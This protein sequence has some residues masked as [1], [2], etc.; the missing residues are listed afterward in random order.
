MRV[1][2]LNIEI[3]FRGTS[4][5]VQTHSEKTPIVRLSASQ[6]QKPHSYALPQLVQNLAKVW[7]V[8]LLQLKTKLVHHI[9]HWVGLS[10]IPW[11]EPDVFSISL[12]MAICISRHSTVQN[13]RK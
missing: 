9:L 10:C 4:R 13:A 12:S 8:V 11:N 3:P 7:Q 5:T 1:G 6:S 2:I